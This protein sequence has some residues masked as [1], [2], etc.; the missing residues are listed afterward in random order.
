MPSIQYTVCWRLEMS[1]KKSPPP[2]EK[3]FTTVKTP[4]SDSKTLKR[5][6]ATPGSPT[7]EEEKRIERTPKRKRPSVGLDS[8]PLA[9]SGGTNKG[10]GGIHRLGTHNVPL[11]ERQQLAMIIRMTDDNSQ[12]SS[13]K[14]SSPAQPPNTP[15]KRTPG[16]KKVHKRN[17]RGETQLHIFAKKGDVKQTKKLIKAGAD[18]NVRDFAGWTALHEAC[19]HGC[20]AVAKQLLKAGAN[21]NVQGLDKDTPLHDASICGYRKLVQL[22]LKHGADPYQANSKGKTAIDVAYSEEIE[23]LLRREN[24]S[25]SGESSSMDEARSPTSPESTAST[26]EDERQVDIDEF[27][28]RISSQMSAGQGTTTTTTTVTRSNSVSAPVSSAASV[29]ST[30]TTQSGDLQFNRDNFPSMHGTAVSSSSVAKRIVPKSP[31]G[32]TNSPRLC[33]KFR[34]S[35]DANSESATASKEWQRYKSY[36]VTLETREPKGS[37]GNSASSSNESDLYDPQLDSGAKL[38]F[39]ESLLHN[40]NNGDGKIAPKIPLDSQ[41]KA[42][43]DSLRVKTYDRNSLERGGNPPLPTPS[44]SPCKP[45]HESIDSCQLSSQFEDIS[46]SEQEETRLPQSTAEQGRRDQKMAGSELSRIPVIRVSTTNDTVSKETVSDTPVSVSPPLYRSSSCVGSPKHPVLENSQDGAERTR[47]N[48]APNKKSILV[49]D[50]LGFK[51]ADCPTWDTQDSHSSPADRWD[52]IASPAIPK[53]ELPSKQ[54]QQISS[55]CSPSS[56]KGEVKT[57]RPLPSLQQ[58]EREPVKS[59]YKTDPKHTCNSPKVPPLKIIM[60]TKTSSSDR[61]DPAGSPFAI[62]SALPYVV[63]PSHAGDG[64]AGVGSVSQDTS[65]AS[66]TASSRPSSRASSPASDKGIVDISKIVDRLSSQAEEEDKAE[67]AEQEVQEKVEN[68]QPAPVNEKPKE[69]KVEEPEKTTMVLRDRDRNKDTE[70]S[71]SKEKDQPAEK[72]NDKGQKE[73]KEQKEERRTTRTLRSHTQMLLQQQKADNQD[74]KDSAQN[75]TAKEE[76]Q[77]KTEETDESLTNRKRKLRPKPEPPTPEPVSVPVPPV[78]YEKPPNPYEL[79]LSIRSQV[80]SRRDGLVT[81]AP[82]APQ[83]Y[84]DYKIVNCSYVL[85]GNS[86]SRLAVP[87]LTPPN[88]VTG[89]IR[90]LFLEQEKARYKLRLQ[91]IVEREKLMMSVEQEV[92]RVH[93]RAARAM[94]NQ[95]LPLGVCTILKD[96]EIY[97]IFEMEERDKNVRT[98]YNGRQFLSWYHDVMDKFDKIKSY[99]LL[100]HHHEAE[101]LYAVQKMDWE[102]KLKELGLCDSNSTPAID[103]LHVPMVQVNEEFDL[104]PA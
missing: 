62:Q 91:H 31:E 87:M 24:V 23:K 38:K 100:R 61:V 104:L 81:V 55:E 84:K 18:V 3:I 59:L 42:V 56:P 22:L 4:Q 41:P 43:A 40:R 29:V 11:S 53:T 95:S 13:P 46:D 65:Q 57:T 74:S 99:L 21:V 58:L 103:E 17:E 6:L 28:L 71:D 39:S 96:E 92:L 9:G 45:S 72:E 33:L 66:S 15:G 89:P 25:S 20:F 12:D 8:S 7:E 35:D 73:A 5:K 97:N 49:S 19:I 36:S 68:S 90:D 88:S 76:E 70:K 30:S 27:A 47:H 98:R 34:S 60:P 44:S 82:K 79:F 78:Q 54:Q 52:T 75:D 1:D 86:A 102:W 93:G 83:G 51:N 69:V 14:H 50:S 2:K 77:Q 26:R 32:K 94:I 80:A 37:P 67:T 64:E 48:S 85:H 101:S 16:D 10:S 63:N